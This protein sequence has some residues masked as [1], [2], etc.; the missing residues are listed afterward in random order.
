MGIKMEAPAS[1]ASRFLSGTAT[2]AAATTA[3]AT[4]DPAPMAPTAPT[5]P[6]PASAIRLC[7]VRYSSY[8]FLSGCS[9]GRPGPCVL[10]TPVVLRPASHSCTDGAGA[11]GGSLRDVPLKSSRGLADV[12]AKR[13]SLN[14]RCVHAHSASEQS[15]PHARRDAQNRRRRSSFWD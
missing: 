2:T 4:T 7:D 1:M 15:G 13:A 3:A 8:H 14:A 6:T 5:A 10:G 9:F 12:G 11:S